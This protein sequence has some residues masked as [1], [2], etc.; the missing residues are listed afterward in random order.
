MSVTSNL[1][2]EPVY[3]SA[4]RRHPFVDE[5]VALLKYR[6]LLRQFVGRAITIRY[7]RSVLGVVWTLLNP[8]LTMIVLSVV[9]STLFRFNIPHYPVY[10]LSSFMVWNFFAAST[11]QAMGEM[12][13]N[14]GL[15]N[16]IYLPKGIIAVSSIG[17][18]I[19][20]MGFTFIPLVLIMLATGASF[21]PTILILPVSLVFLAAFAMGMGLMLATAAVFF[22]DMI[23][24]YEVLL[25]IWFY[26]TPIIYP[27]DIIPERWLWLFK[28]NPMYYL[29][30]LF[31]QPIFAGKIPDLSTWLIAGGYALA[32]LCLGWYI[33]TSKANEYAYRV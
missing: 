15:M 27:I 11:N 13:L 2:E 8:L 33:F 29:V 10:L 6:E 5:F 25:S 24:V 30:D 9:F 7:K 12:A 1:S 14:A 17:T 28:L 16:R 32:V 19:V 21:S 4:K 23:P 3:D 31:R 20:N 26:S 22:A 18:A